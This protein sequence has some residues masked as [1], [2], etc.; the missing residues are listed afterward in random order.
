M[1]WGGEHTKEHIAN[2][3]IIWEWDNPKDAFQLV[4]EPWDK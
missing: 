3:Q 2:K 4:F 1:Y